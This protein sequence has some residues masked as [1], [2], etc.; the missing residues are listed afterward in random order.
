MTAPNGVKSNR[1]GQMKAE[2]PLSLRMD[3]SREV[4]GS[5]RKFNSTT[6]D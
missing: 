2:M 3:E 6:K 1:E 5:G 4:Y